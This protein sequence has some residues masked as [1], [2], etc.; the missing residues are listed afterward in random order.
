MKQ[1]TV[2][3]CEHCKTQYLNRDYAQ[4]CEENHKDI[5]KI[6]DLK[7]LPIDRKADGRP[8][9]I[10]IEFANGTE[11]YYRKQANMSRRKRKKWLKKNGNYVSYNEL[12]NLDTTIAEW[13]LPR[14]R[15]FREISDGY[16]SVLSEEE[17]NEILDKIIHGF[18][19][20]AGQFQV[21]PYIGNSE[22]IE[23]EI[24]EGMNLFAKWIRALWI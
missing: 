5:K 7:Y 11:W 19:L 8:E 15:R 22:R 23:T 16:P 4:K 21:E 14:L 2:Y 9:R 20:I 24:E 17:W 3:V 18:E 6:I 12:W 1:E 10:K 13:I